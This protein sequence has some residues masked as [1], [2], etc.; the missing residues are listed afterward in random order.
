[1]H[2]LS[3]V[4]ALIDLCEQNAASQKA[5]KVL[6]VYVDLGVLSG[7][8]PQLFRTCFES[9]CNDGVCKGAKLFL[10]IIPLYGRC[11]S[12]NKGSKLSKNVFLC[13]KCKSHDFVLEAGEDLLLRSLV[14]E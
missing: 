7:V 9:F 3:I 8:E 13:P 5:S 11:K 10:N 14:M 4:S 2:E 1:M 12:C 6:E